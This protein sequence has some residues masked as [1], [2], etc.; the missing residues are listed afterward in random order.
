MESE[1]KATSYI[2]IFVL[3]LLLLFLFLYNPSATSEQLYQ[4]MRLCAETL[5]PALFPYL[6]ISEMLVRS[7]AVSVISPI[8]GKVTERSEEHTSELQ[9]R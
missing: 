2:A 5:I 6:V 9:S 8:I 3:C 4:G 7:G 1:K